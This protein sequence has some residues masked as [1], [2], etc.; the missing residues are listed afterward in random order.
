MV[1]RLSALRTGR[2]YPKEMLLV[3]ISV[4][5]WVD[6][7]AI[8]RSEGLCQR[9]IPMTPSGIEPATFQFVAQYLKHCTT[10]VPRWGKEGSDGKKTKT[11][12]VAT[13]WFSEKERLLEIDK[14]STRSHTVEN[15][16]WNRLWIWNERSNEWMNEWMRGWMNGL[17]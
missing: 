5:G 9:K 12:Q 3:L 13:G 17:V 6:P 14:R 1:V 2:L 8:L 16:F 10:A 7:R 15:R 4:R 11:M